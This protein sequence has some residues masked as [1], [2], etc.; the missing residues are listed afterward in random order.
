[1]QTAFPNATPVKRPIFE[2]ATI[3]DP[4]WLAGFTEGESCFFVQLRKSPTHKA[5][6][7]VILHFRITQHL[8][9][10]ALINSLIGYLGCGSVVVHSKESSVVYLVNKISDILEKILPFFSK[11]PLQ[12]AKGQDFKDWCKVAHIMETKSHLTQL[13]LEDI[14]LIKAGMNRGRS[15]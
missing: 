10:Q 11:Y 15:V 9:D 4:N 1:L 13:G 8:R 5:G 7:Q 2:G 3:K 12:G 14:R 6:V